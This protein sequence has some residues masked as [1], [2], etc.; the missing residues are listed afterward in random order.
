MDSLFYFV[1]MRA[2]VLQELNELPQLQTINLN[3]GEKLKVETQYSAL[4]HRDLWIKKGKFPGIKKGVKLG[5]DASV[6]YP[7]RRYI[8]NP[9][10]NW[11][12]IESHQSQKFHVLGLPSHGTFS[13]QI[14]IDR[15]YLFDIPDHLSNEQAAALPLAGV[16]AFRAL[17][18]R[19]QLQKNEKVLINGAGGGVAHFALLFALAISNQVYVTSGS[20]QK[21]EISKKMGAVDGFNYKNHSSMQRMKE[22]VPEGFDVIIDS[23]AGEGFEYLLKNTAY[24][25]RIAMYG[26]TTGKITNLNPQLLFWRQISILGST[27]GSDHDFKEMLDFVTKHKITP[28]IDKVYDLADFKKAF[29]RM[30]NQ[31]QFGKIVLKHV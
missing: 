1:P 31:D 27:M 17:L 4:N 28:V 6:L 22:A 15:E 12:P 25:G 3:C 26:G 8:I 2:L 20:D 5:S 9:G 10:L 14:C 18:K 13:D 7:N 19:A 24:G 21:I 16:T 30:E 11:G 29:Q 23:A